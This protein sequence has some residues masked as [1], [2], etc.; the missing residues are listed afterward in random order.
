MQPC[1][2]RL[3]LEPRQPFELDVIGEVFAGV[4][5]VGLA[6]VKHMIPHPPDSTGELSK[7]LALLFRGFE[8]VDKSFVNQHRFAREYTGQS[9]R[10]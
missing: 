1:S 5:I 4:L 8:L 6:L 9:F 7:Q 10:H 3:S 2:L